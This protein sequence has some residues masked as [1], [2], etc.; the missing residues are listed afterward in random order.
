MTIALSDIK[1]RIGSTA[2]IKKVTGTLQKV[3]GAKLIQDLRRLANADNYFS[4]LCLLLDLA[5]RTLPMNAGVHPLL[6]VPPEGLPIALLV[7]GSDRGL[8]G[9]FN[10]LL[11]KSVTAFLQDHTGESV[12]V[13][14]RGKISYNRALRLQLHPIEYVETAEG[15][16]ARMIDTFLKKQVGRVYIMHWDFITKARQE[17]AIRQVLPATFENTVNAASGSPSPLPARIEPSPQ[18]LIESLLPEYINRSIYNAV[19]KS[20]AAENTQRQAAMSRAT[21]NAGSMLSDLRKQYSRLRQESI[22][23]E[24][25]EI[26]A[27]LYR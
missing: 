26:V 3:A 5:R 7:F 16:G 24:M 9:S 13:F 6:N 2:Q 14:F 10:S 22:T 18:A 12:T 17:I 1:R 8:C 21:E 20:A 4:R 23:T 15:L 11:I 25:L 27:G 19:H